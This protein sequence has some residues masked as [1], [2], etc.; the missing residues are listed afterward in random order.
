MHCFNHLSNAPP[1]VNLKDSVLDTIFNRL[2]RI[3][4]IFVA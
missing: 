3:F 4:T 1:C 2:R